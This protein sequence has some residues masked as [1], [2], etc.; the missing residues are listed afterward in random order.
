MR[1]KTTNAAD[2]DAMMT[3]AATTTTVLMLMAAAAAAVAAKAS[4]TARPQRKQWQN[5]IWKYEIVSVSHA[6]LHVFSCVFF[7]LCHAKEYCMCIEERAR[8]NIR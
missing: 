4:T 8:A 7:S 2:D 6:I 1:Q 3:M 5:V